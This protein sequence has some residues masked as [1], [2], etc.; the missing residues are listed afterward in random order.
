MK[1]YI[2]IFMLLSAACSG[3]VTVSEDEIGADVFYVKDSYKP[4]TG[5]CIVVFRNSDLVKEEFT[6][7]NGVLQGEAL[8]WHKNGQLRRKGS[9]HKGQISGKW[10]FFNEQGQK[11]IE[12]YYKQD[13]LNG[14]FISLYHNGKIKEKGRFERNK[15][16]GQWDY[17]TENGQLIE[18]VNR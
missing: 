9:Y 7:R 8:A 3:K 18:S 2:Y 11:T 5:K 16:I 4:F 14:S 13:N 6:F 1:W 17:F 10:E 15:K 12:A